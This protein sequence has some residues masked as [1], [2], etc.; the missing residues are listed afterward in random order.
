VS[1]IQ[2]SNGNDEEPEVEALD[3]ERQ[4]DQAS[5]EDVDR[6]ADPGVPSTSTP[7]FYAN[8]ADL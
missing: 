6:D 5:S 3:S 1:T 2:H 4:T 8:L 7:R